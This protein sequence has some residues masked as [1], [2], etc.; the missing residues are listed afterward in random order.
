MGLVVRSARESAWPCPGSTAFGFSDP[1][2]K[3]VWRI[4]QFPG[5][6]RPAAEKH[7]RRSHH[8]LRR[9]NSGDDVTGAATVSLDQFLAVPV[10][11][12]MLTA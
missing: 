9:M 2:N 10:L 4:R 8:A 1:P 7:Q 12:S 5:D 6:H 3:V 11:P